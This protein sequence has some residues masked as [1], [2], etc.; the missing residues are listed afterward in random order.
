MNNNIKIV[1]NREDFRCLIRGGQLSIELKDSKVQ[2]IL[3]DIGFNEME[4]DI[5][6]YRYNKQDIMKS[7]TR[8]ESRD[9]IDLNPEK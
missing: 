1:L 6:Y 9:F 4:N 8:C 7:W 3:Q 2:M 5:D